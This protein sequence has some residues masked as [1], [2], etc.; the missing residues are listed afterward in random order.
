[1]VGAGRPAAGGDRWRRGQ[2]AEPAPSGRS[3]PEPSANS[4]FFIK[5]A[6]GSQPPKVTVGLWRE[7]NEAITLASNVPAAGLALAQSSTG[8]TPISACPVAI[9]SGPE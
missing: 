5:T 1:M 4:R 6:M 3:E 2:R 9:V 7:L 8:D